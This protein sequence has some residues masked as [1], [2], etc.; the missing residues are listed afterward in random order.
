MSYEQNSPSGATG[1][2]RPIGWLPNTPGMSGVVAGLGGGLAMII[3]AAM[4]SVALGFDMWRE[5]REIAAP[6]F[7]L[8]AA[9]ETMAI[10][11]GTLLHFL[12]SAL[13]GAVFEILTVKLL[14]LP[15]DYGVSAVSGLI[16]GLVL[17]AGAYFVVLPLVN[18]VLLGTYAPSFVIQNLVYGVVTGV[19]YGML[20]PTPYA[21]GDR[22][23]PAV[24]DRA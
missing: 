16:Y 4:L 13:L 1:G 14:R 10:V 2:R 15:T 18:P 5:P 21:T 23:W 12:I 24:P 8:V 7:G 17:W 6:I 19:L 22:P 11:V 20:R 9:N 3:V